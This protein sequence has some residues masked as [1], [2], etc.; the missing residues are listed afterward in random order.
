MVCNINKS[1]KYSSDSISIQL[2]L[3]SLRKS[4]DA[5]M[6]CWSD[7]HLLPAIVLK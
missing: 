1:H 3:S 4:Q 7:I 2:A 6:K 5:E